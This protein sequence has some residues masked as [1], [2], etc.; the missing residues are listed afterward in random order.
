[1]G[2]HEGV[3]RYQV[4]QVA[5]DTRVQKWSRKGDKRAELEDDRG[6]AYKVN[7]QSHAPNQS[8]SLSTNPKRCN[9]KERM[10]WNKIGLW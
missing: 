1:M 3:W 5:D 7:V 8:S 9:G 4:G 6:Q 10:R 2:E